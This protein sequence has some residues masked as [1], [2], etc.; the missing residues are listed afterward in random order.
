MH[1]TAPTWYDALIMLSGFACLVTLFA[2]LL[3]ARQK[4]A[5]RH[6]TKVSKPLDG[7][8]EAF[9]RFRTEDRRTPGESG[10][11]TKESDRGKSSQSTRGH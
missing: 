9:S 1:N 4:F 5:E 11:Y 7:R 3:F 6:L 8:N 2:I 10:V